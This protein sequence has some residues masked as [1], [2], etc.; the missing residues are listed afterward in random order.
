MLRPVLSHLGLIVAASAT[1]YAKAKAAAGSRPRREVMLLRTCGTTC[2]PL[3]KDLPHRDQPSNCTG[4]DLRAQSIACNSHSAELAHPPPSLPGKARTRGPS[5]TI[6]AQGNHD[7][8]KTKLPTLQMDPPH[9]PGNR[10]P[11]GCGRLQRPATSC[12]IQESSHKLYICNSTRPDMAE[13]HVSKGLCHLPF[14]SPTSEFVYPSFSASHPHE[15]LLC[16]GEG[17]GGGRGFGPR[18]RNTANATPSYSLNQPVS[19]WPIMLH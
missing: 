7:K 1:L 9:L 10:Q 14:G 6:S 3:V 11:L 4:L 8:L 19:K 12:R 13:F 17:G 18:V 15:C 5:T 2:P 16:L